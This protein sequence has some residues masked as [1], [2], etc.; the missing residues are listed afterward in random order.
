MQLL[1]CLPV[2]IYEYVLCIIGLK[3][4]IFLKCLEKDQLIVSLKI[5]FVFHKKQKNNYLKK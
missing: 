1:L 3:K 4:K 5:V 2:Y